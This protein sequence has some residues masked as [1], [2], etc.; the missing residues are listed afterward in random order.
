MNGSGSGR[1][2]TGH[3]AAKHTPSQTPVGELIPAAANADS[4]E[5][6]GITAENHLEF[7]WNL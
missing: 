6:S 3:E 5:V 2:L 7:Q 4:F 1:V